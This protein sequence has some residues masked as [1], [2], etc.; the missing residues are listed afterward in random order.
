MRILHSM[1][2]SKPR[3]RFCQK[4]RLSQKGSC[5]VGTCVEGHNQHFK[6]YLHFRCHEINFDMCLIF[7]T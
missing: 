7:S 6:A 3:N 5:N 4:Q 1:E 2:F